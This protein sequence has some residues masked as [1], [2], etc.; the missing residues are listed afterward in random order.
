MS[1]DI[2]FSDTL[3]NPP[4]R[5]PAIWAGARASVPISIAAIPFGIVTGIAATE[6]GLSP[7][8][9]MLMS[10]SIFAGAAQLAC[11]QLI[12]NDGPALVAVLT[13]WII[14]LRHILYSASLAPHLAQVSRPWQLLMAYLMTDQAYVNGIGCENDRRQ[15]ETLPWFFLGGGA[16]IWV[17]YQIANLVGV[18]V[19]SGAPAELSLEFV[20]TLTFLAMLVTTVV[21]RHL[22]MAALVGGTTAVVAAP[23]PYN[24]GLMLAAVSGM[25]AGTITESWQSSE[26]SEHD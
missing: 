24:L 9:A 23:L 19:G 16:L 26:V 14:N 1:S 12:A 18:S 25:L 4:S 5:L 6:A 22:L 3:G 20:A 11:A 2:C 8:M 10:L 17:V 13:V 21:D 15:R 7:I